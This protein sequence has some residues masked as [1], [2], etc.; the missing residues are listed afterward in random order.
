[1]NDKYEFEEVTIFDGPMEET[2]DGS[3]GT[4]EKQINDQNEP[5]EPGKDLF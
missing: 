2:T 5:S 1:M 3:I 4:Y